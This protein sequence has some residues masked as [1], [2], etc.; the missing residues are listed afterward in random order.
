MT[1]ASGANGWLTE[2]S[3]LWDL[4]NQRAE[5]TPDER[6]AIDEDGRS[7]T[8]EQYRDAALR[9]AAGFA[10]LGIGEGDVV[11][12][13]LPTWLESM[14][15]VGG[16]SRLGAVQNPILPI[17]RDRE[18]GFVVRESGAKVLVVTG[19][20][21]GFDYAAMADSIAIETPGL[22]VVVVERNNLPEGDPAR[23]APVP[24]GASQN[25]AP[26]EQIDAPLRWLFY[27]SGTTANPTG[28]R[29]TDMTVAYSG[30]V[31]VD[32]F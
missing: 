2:W 20:W 13:Q 26:G 25:F 21:R 3:S 9:C 32:A 24:T 10:A 31:M 18:V 16:L 28:A 17:Y 11:S 5:A 8:F 14:V 6:F 22:K 29:H 27:T 19:E 12:W 7:L 4:I 30:Y 1:Q 23:L 15:L